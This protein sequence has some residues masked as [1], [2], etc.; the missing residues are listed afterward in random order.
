MSSVA[1]R[2]SHQDDTVE[3]DVINKVSHSTA[4]SDIMRLTGKLASGQEKSLFVFD[5]A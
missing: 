3:D 5:I 1:L 4:S 2:I